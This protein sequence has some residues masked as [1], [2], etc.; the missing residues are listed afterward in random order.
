MKK[1]WIFY[2]ALCAVGWVCAD[3]TIDPSHPYAYAA[4][5]GWLNAAGDVTN[6]AVIGQAYCTGYVWSANC[7]WICLGNGPTNGWL[8]SNASSNDWGVNHDGAGSLSGYAY[9]A[10]IGWINFEQT[11]GRPHIDLW[12][13]NLD[14]YVWSANIGWIGLSNTYAYVRTDS[15]DAGPDSDGDGIPDPWEYRMGGDLPTFT[16]G[17]HDED[18]DGVPDVEEYPAD[19]D[20]TD[21]A[22]MLAITNFQRQSDTNSLTWTIEQTRFY[23]LQQATTLTAAAAWSDSGL[24]QMSPDPGPSM[25]REVVDPSATP[26][27]YRVR[28]SI[29]L[30]E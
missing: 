13:G 29:P 23:E 10:N 9:G 11:H 15:L 21:P 14:G 1:L 20:P 22:D 17:G 26:R 4:N 28:A 19:T 25:T 3:T 16:D 7:G 12:N 5:A 27:F 6:G 18:A 24:G 2:I 8:Y 30:L